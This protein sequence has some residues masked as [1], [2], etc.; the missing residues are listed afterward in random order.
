MKRDRLTIKG[1]LL[2]DIADAGPEGAMPT[3]LMMKM[4]TSWVVIMAL[5][6]ELMEDGLVVATRRNRWHRP[7]Q[8]PEGW[9]GG[10]PMRRRLIYSLTERGYRIL[11]TYLV[12]KE[13]LGP[14]EKAMVP[15]VDPA[16]IENV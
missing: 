3:H 11:K 2:Q 7:G 8:F 4:S 16:G 6:R 14:H 5:V 12:V 15:F 9:G 13:A 1:D 10:K